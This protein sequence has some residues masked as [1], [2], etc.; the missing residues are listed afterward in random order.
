VDCFLAAGVVYSFQPVLLLYYTSLY[1][2]DESSV[3]IGDMFTLGQL[4][5]SDL[6]IVANDIGF[7][8]KSWSCAPIE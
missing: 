4:W 8:T 1:A 6:G 5:I 7:Q 3:Y 2:K